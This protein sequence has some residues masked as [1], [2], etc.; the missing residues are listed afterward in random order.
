MDLEA[1]RME[2]LKLMIE[3]EMDSYTIECVLVLI[4]T[5]EEV[6]EVLNYIKKYEKLIT[7]HQLRQY[8]VKIKDKEKKKKI[9]TLPLVE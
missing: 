5:K 9:K 2:L 8:I 6:E 3:T 1:Q 7:D 4:Q